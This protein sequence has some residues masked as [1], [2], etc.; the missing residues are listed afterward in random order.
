MPALAPCERPLLS[1]LAS[2]SRLAAAAP[3]SAAVASAAM[4][5]VTAVSPAF[6]EFLDVVV[7]VVVMSV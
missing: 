7:M 5:S 4:S 2:E 1:E 6:S 3:R